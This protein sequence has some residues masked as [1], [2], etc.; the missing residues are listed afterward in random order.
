MLTTP[1]IKERAV[2]EHTSD[3]NI[4]RE[5]CQHLFLA[6]LYQQPASDKLY[7]K[8]G[9]ALRILYKS[10]RFSED[11]DFESPQ[12][13]ITVIE[14]AI[15]GALAAIENLGITTELTEAT[16]TSGGYLSS[17]IFQ[18]PEYRIESRLEISLRSSTGK[19]DVVTVVND[20]IPTYTLIQLTQKQLVD[21]KIKALLSRHKPRDFYDLY[22]I[23]RAN[24]LP[25]EE[26]KILP[27]ALVVLQQAELSFE[28]ELKEFLP[29]SHWAV[30]KDLPAVLEREIGRFI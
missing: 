28:S 24:L 17:A 7:F 14:H 4:A 30:I 15:V 11:L 6:S 21:G 1:Q 3:I 10:P 8:S 27:E 22:F 23:L 12:K 9:T 18:L 19:G 16:T 20:Y 5:Y 29:R 13:D 26:R 25:P 2:H